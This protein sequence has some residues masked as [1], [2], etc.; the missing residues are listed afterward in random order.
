MTSD[1]ERRRLGEIE[2]ELR[3]D[4]PTLVRQF[5]EWRPGARR[6][7]IL[8]FLVVIAIVLGWALSGST[9][10]I[11]A[12]V[13]TV[14][15]FRDWDALGVHKPLTRLL[16]GTDLTQ[17]RD[18]GERPGITRIAFRHGFS[19]YFDTVGLAVA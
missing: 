4:D 8:A 2:M 16:S 11:I 1:S 12:L 5:D 19:E 9:A 14:S 18:A 17:R 6:R 15:G 10:G 3:R 7:P 13:G